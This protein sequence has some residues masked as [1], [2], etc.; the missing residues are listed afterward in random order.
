[1]APTQMNNLMPIFNEAAGRLV[2]QWKDGQKSA[3]LDM[4][5]R[6]VTLEVICRIT[7]SW[8]RDRAAVFPKLF[9]EIIDELNQRMFQ[10]WRAFMP[11]E[12]THQSR[13]TKLNRI[14][15]MII[16]ERKAEYVD[17]GYDKPLMELQKTDAM[18]AASVE[19]LKPPLNNRQAPDILDALLHAD[20]NMPMQQVMDELKTMLLAGHETTSMMLTWALFLLI[21]NP[22][23]MAKA[24]A[25]VDKICQDKE[26]F[27]EDGA[28]Y[29]GAIPFTRA[30]L[31]RLQFL[32]WAMMEGMRVFV[33]VPTL[34]R[35]TSR[36]EKW[37][38]HKIPAGTRLLLSVYSTH[39]SP[40]IWG[41]TYDQF[42]PERMAPE[43]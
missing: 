3:E 34:T 30:D 10:P 37:Q 42:R 22:K 31:N 29:G 2:T 18:K 20:F 9:S 36:D 4:T 8:S 13:L 1:M 14:V 12:L 43:Q 23:E 33:P 7:L 16:N 26:R 17:A 39:M 15:K 5:F 19:N 24:T 40:K 38:G 27:G 32:N 28:P 6:H 35:V 25:V 41:P 21:K 11:L